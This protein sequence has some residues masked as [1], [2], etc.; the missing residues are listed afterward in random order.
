MIVL[1]FSASVVD[2]A[3]VLA[4]ST[5]APLAVRILVWFRDPDLM[6]QFVA[7]VG[8]LAQMGL[9]LVCCGIWAVTSAIWARFIRH[10]CR[11]GWRLR[12]KPLLARVG[13]FWLLGLAVL[14]CA[15][16][17]AGLISSLIWAFADIWRFPDGLPSRWGVR[18]WMM[19]GDALVLAASQSCSGLG[20]SFCI[21]VCSC[22]LAGR[23][24]F[25]NKDRT[26]W[27]GGQLGGHAS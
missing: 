18:A 13:R 5:P 17:A 11:S 15:L 26:V 24:L 22:V 14:P 8:A 3:V 19:T 21:C 27:G 25:S 6:R 20:G 10:I 7:A 2:M 23:S 1:V 12:T 9:A 4:P 16:A